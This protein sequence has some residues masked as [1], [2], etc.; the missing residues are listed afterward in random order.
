M[1]FL[2]IKP[3]FKADVPTHYI[4][5]CVKS[6]YREAGTCILVLKKKGGV[7]VMFYMD[8]VEE[9]VSLTFRRKV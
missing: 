2:K 4:K 8:K 5:I 6:Q 9:E 7:D 3:A 1:Y